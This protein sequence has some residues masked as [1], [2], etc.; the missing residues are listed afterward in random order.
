MHHLAWPR[1]SA[2]WTSGS[3]A[4]EDSAKADWTDPGAGEF[5]SLRLFAFAWL[6]PVPVGAAF[7]QLMQE[8]GLA[9][10]T[11]LLEAM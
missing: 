5:D 7:E 3:G 6:D 9:I 2:S 1:F 8:A 10:E 4:A 11:R